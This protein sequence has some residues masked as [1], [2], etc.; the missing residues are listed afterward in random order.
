M[1]GF[2]NANPLARL[3]NDEPWSAMHP[4]AAMNL[5]SDLRSQSYLHPSSGFGAYRDAPGSDI[6]GFAETIDSGYRTHA[7]SIISQE[8]CSQDHDLPNSI[9]F[10][11]DQMNVDHVPSEPGD[12]AYTALSVDQASQHSG[13][14]RS[15]VSGF[16]KPIKCTISGCTKELKCPSEA[17]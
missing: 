2:D 10:Q 3:G 12:V 4:R 17:K 6:G 8:P 5:G 15:R 9:T 7:R 16:K 13:H 11:M 14:S 1:N